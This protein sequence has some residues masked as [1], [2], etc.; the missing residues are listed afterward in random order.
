[1]NLTLYFSIYNN[2][3]SNHIAHKPN[4]RSVFKFKMEDNLY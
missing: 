4:F 2:V 3:L 1:M